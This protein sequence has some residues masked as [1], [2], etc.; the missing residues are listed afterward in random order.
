MSSSNVSPPERDYLEAYKYC[1]FGVEKKR[2]KSF[3]NNA[4]IKISA[5]EDK[6]VAFQLLE[7][8]KRLKPSLESSETSPTREELGPL[9]QPTALPS[10]MT[11][12]LRSNNLVDHPNLLAHGQIYTFDHNGF[13]TLSVVI[14]PPISAVGKIHSTAFTVHNDEASE[15][16]RLEVTYHQA[17]Y[18]R[19]L[20][21]TLTRGEFSYSYSGLSVP[22][23]VELTH[24][25]NLVQAVRT[26]KKK[27]QG[28]PLDTQQDHWDIHL[29]KM[30]EM[31]VLPS[32]FLNGKEYPGKWELYRTGDDFV[33][34]AIWIVTFKQRGNLDYHNY[35]FTEQS[36]PTRT[37]IDESEY[38]RYGAS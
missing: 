10:V 15:T 18:I 12:A 24:E 31:E 23:D 5:E 9:S 35:G 32:L 33:S 1:P 13:Q 27:Q 20:A 14:D 7:E 29:P 30:V 38:D 22:Q 2:F 6:Q 3:F 25:T 11:K 16:A 28:S 26:S 34:R 19:D 8:K 37:F 21:E 4:K 36:N 17:P